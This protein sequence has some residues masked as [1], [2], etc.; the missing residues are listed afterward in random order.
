MRS[1]KP[2]IQRLIGEAKQPEKSTVR[3]KARAI[4]KAAA[5]TCLGPDLGLL[6]RCLL[7]PARGGGDFHLGK[8][9]ENPARSRRRNL[10]YP[11]VIEPVIVP[12]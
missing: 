6:L 9:G 1:A 5:R 11:R 4:A 7:S 2:H 3:A 8:S 12:R 10:E